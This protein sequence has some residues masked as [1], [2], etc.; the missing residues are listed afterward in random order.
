[1]PRFFVRPEDVIQNKIKIFG[2]EYNH[3]KNV[4]RL[5]CGEKITVSDG[6]GTDYTAVIDSFESNS[7]VASIL[8]SQSSTTEPPIDV[9]LYQGVPKS[10]KMDLII[11]KSVELGIKKIVPVLTE[12]TIVKFENEKDI[13]TK[14]SRWQR[15][16]LEA[17]KQCNRGVVPVIERPMAYS[18]AIE[19]SKDSD[20]R[21]IPFE[22]EKDNTLK[23]ILKCDSKKSISFFIGPEGGFSE[24]EVIRAKLSGVVPV[25]LGPR[26][27]RT[28]T[29][30]FVVLSILMYEL[31]DVSL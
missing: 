2:D 8:S 3:I 17:S 31:G 26:I 1:M 15:I 19:S 18:N 24:D 20:L 14:V 5:K 11:Q 30:G 9:V 4:L 10:D 12:R 29:A 25:T 23:S 28:E 13:N 27:L 7:V 22:N 16:A 6:T 21:I